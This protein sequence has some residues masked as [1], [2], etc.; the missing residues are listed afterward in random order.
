MCPRCQGLLVNEWAFDGEDG[1]KLHYQRCVICGFYTDAQMQENRNKTPLTK[2][3]TT[4]QSERMA[5]PQM[6]EVVGK[7]AAAVPSLE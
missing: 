2:I 1:G 7:L 5:Y 3:R 4:W 6:V